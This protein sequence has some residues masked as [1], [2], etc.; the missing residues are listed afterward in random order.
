MA[1]RSY[2]FTQVQT[3]SANSTKTYTIEV[4][5]NEK[6]TIDS[7]KMAVT[8]TTA[9]ITEIKDSAGVPYGS[10]SSTN[11]MKIDVF[12]PST[13]MTVGAFKLSAPIV[14]SGG[15]KLYITILDG[16]GAS[17]TVEVTAIGRI[18]AA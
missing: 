11:K 9:Y 18:E 17:N 6:L 14:L 4:G 8:S 10:L 5:V 15:K 12:V 3:I 13:S 2:F 7:I 16:S 1:E